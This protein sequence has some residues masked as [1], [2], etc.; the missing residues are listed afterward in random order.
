[1]RKPRKLRIRKKGDALLQ[2]TPRRIL[3]GPIDL[4]SSKK[5]DKPNALATVFD[6]EFFHLDLLPEPRHHVSDE[7]DWRPD[8]YWVP[9][10]EEIDPED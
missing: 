3:E 2:T 6:A 5:G 8:D 1:M 10:P 7:E 4:N 9:D